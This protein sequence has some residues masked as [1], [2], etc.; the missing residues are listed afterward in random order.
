[1]RCIRSQCPSLRCWTRCRTRMRSIRLLVRSL[2]HPPITP[3]PPPT[4]CA[5]LVRRSRDIVRRRASSDFRFLQAT[6]TTPERTAASPGRSGAS[7]RGRSLPLR[8]APTR[9][10]RS[11]SDSS[12]RSR[13]FVSDPVCSL[14]DAYRRSTSILPSRL[15]SRRPSGASSL[16]PRTSTSSAFLLRPV[17]HSLTRD[18][19]VRVYQ[20]GKPNVGCN[21]ASHR[22]SLVARPAHGWNGSRSRADD[23]ALSSYDGLHRTSHGCLHQVRAALF[24]SLLARISADLAKFSLCRY[25]PNLTSWITTPGKTMPKNSLAPGGC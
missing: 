19:Y 17:R 7:R 6:S 23:P 25:S 3:C 21:P 10:L 1:M 4:L 13:W 20:K 14:A 2:S 5:V 16:S 18:S 22:T 24:A 12:R 11:R 15:R 8:L 9:R